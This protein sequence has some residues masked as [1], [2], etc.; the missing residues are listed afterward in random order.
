M[1]ASRW[2]QLLNAGEVEW[3]KLPTRYEQSNNRQ[4]A[5]TLCDSARKNDSVMFQ[6]RVHLSALMLG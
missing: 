1:I 6:T 4:Y 5:I 2:L 3:H